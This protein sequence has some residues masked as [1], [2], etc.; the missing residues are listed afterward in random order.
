MQKRPLITFVPKTL[1]LRSPFLAEIGNLFL[2]PYNAEISQKFHD[3]TEFVY[4]RSGKGCLRYEDLTFN[5]QAGDVVYLSP[6]MAHYLYKTEPDT[7]RCEFIHINL[8]KMVDPE[9]FKDLSAFTDKLLVPF[10]IPPVLSGKEYP[11]ITE[12]MGLLLEEMGRYQPYLSLSVQ[13]YCMCIT[14]ELRKIW[15]QNKSRQN[16]SSHDYL[17]QAA[18]YMNQH[19]NEDLSIAQLAQI[20]NLSETHFRRLFKSKF[21]MSPLKYLNLIRVRESCVLLS[22][23]PFQI[24]EIAEMAG[25]QT[26]SSFNRQFKE[27]MGQSPT[28]WINH[29]IATEDTPQVHFYG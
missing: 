20:C 13:G 7:C 9:I 1:G 29:L 10:S 14:S 16:L 2:H 23:K 19:Y 12:L 11:K 25:F 8:R 22:R 18:I 17:Y 24:S 5:F 4:C 26:L 15:E 28:E 3:C 6:Y 27:I 21:S